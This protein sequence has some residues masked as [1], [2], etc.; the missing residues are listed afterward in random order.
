MIR[1]AELCGLWHGHMALHGRVVSQSDFHA[2]AVK[3]L[4]LNRHILPYLGPFQRVYVPEPK[5]RAG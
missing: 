3:E 2:W 1:C 4:A 5:H